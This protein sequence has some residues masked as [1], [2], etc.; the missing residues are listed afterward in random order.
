MCQAPTQGPPLWGSA[1]ETGALVKSG[2]ALGPTA[3]GFHCSAVGPGTRSA[4]LGPAPPPP[5]NCLPLTPPPPPWP[6]A[7]LLRLPPAGDLAPCPTV[8]AAGP[9]LGHK[10]GFIL[11]FLS[12]LNSFIKLE[13]LL[14]DV[15]NYFFLKK[16]PQNPEVADARRQ[17]SQQP[18][19]SGGLGGGSE[20]PE[21]A[22]VSGRPGHLLAGW[23]GKASPQFLACVT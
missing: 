23:P 13:W 4:L 17:L 15:N 11:C 1:I 5:P 20:T 3:W 16:T 19:A 12:I 14:W 18:H 22:H 9:I 6:Q 10:Q 7:R 2:A 21:G 8:G